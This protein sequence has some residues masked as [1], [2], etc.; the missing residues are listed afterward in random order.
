MKKAAHKY[1]AKPTRIG[2]V[3]FHSKGEAKRWSDLLWLEKAG[4][5][6]NLK[7]QVPI[8]LSINGV[9]ICRMIVDF[10]YTDPTTGDRILEDFKGYVTPEWKLKF[11]IFKALF[12]NQRFIINY[13]K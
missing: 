13:G 10:G 7:R 3:Y 4:A 6:K 9:E 1:N 11:K 12:P 5:V 2:G 8:S